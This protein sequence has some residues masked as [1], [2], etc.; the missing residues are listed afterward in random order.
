MRRTEPPPT[1]LSVTGVEPP[2]GSSNPSPAGTT[3]VPGWARIA[4]SPESRTTDVASPAEID[5][6]STCRLP[7]A[8][9]LPR[10]STTSATPSSWRIRSTSDA[11][12]CEPDTVRSTGVTRSS[13]WVSVAETE[14]APTISVEMRVTPT[15]SAPAA[16]AVRRGWRV[17]CRAAKLAGTPP[18]SRRGNS[19][20]AA[21]SSRTVSGTSSGQSA[22]TPMNETS[23]PN[24]PMGS[25][26]DRAPTAI[27]RQPKN[28]TS[29]PAASRRGFAPRP[30][31]GVSMPAGRSASTGASRPACTAGLA[32][33]SAVTT[34]PPSSGRASW[35]ADGSTNANGTGTDVE[36]RTATMTPATPS[37][38]TRPATA[39]VA[40]S[41]RASPSTSRTTCPR[42]APTQR[43]SAN[44]RARWTMTIRSVFA[45]T[46][47]ATNSEI[48]AKP[49]RN[50]PSTS[51]SSVRLLTAFA[52]SCAAVATS[53]PGNR[54]STRP[55]S[56]DAE[57]PPAASTSTSPS[58]PGTCQLLSAPAAVNTV[59][60]PGHPCGARRCRRPGPSASPS[61]PCPSID[62]LIVEPMDSWAALAVDASRATSSAPCG[63]RPESSD[64]HR[65]DDDRGTSATVSKPRPAPA[66]PGK[67]TETVCTASAAATPGRREICDRSRLGRSRRHER[68]DVGSAVLDGDRVARALAGGSGERQRGD[69]EADSQEHREHGRHGAAQVVPPARRR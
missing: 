63:Q 45:T 32:A 8:I 17:A 27:T 7:T 51:T 49:S 2:P 37:P 13:A 69:A 3:S 54:P 39:P 29:T 60:A 68:D 55:T 62:A 20:L 33:A 4:R 16:A 58:V 36:L 22:S 42:C 38:A 46:S 6:T 11:G 35:D 30:M 61:C 25:R 43:S 5:A 64:I 52:R 21:E 34:S 26:P 28:P 14:A 66:E 24:K 65:S 12:T 10:S 18:R 41:S 19:R 59:A 40:P 9:R 1:V 23:P 50:S 48:A 15:S 53:M 56:A 57:T 47:P 31:T 44:S 67:S